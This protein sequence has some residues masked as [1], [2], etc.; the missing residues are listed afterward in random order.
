VIRRCRLASVAL[1]R[2]FC[3]RNI[4]T[5]FSRSVLAVRA[6]EG[7]AAFAPASTRSHRWQPVAFTRVAQPFSVQVSSWERKI[8]AGQL[9]GGLEFQK[10]R[11]VSRGFD[12]GGESAKCRSRGLPVSTSADQTPHMFC[13]FGPAYRDEDRR[14]SVT[15]PDCKPHIYLLRPP[16]DNQLSSATKFFGIVPRRRHQQLLMI[17]DCFLYSV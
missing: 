17:A 10:Y 2:R 11:A 14:Q 12:S 4:R 1:F 6:P 15:P 9:R 8:N 5:I 16:P 3:R 7:E 13:R